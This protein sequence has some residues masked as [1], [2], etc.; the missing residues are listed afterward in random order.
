MNDAGTAFTSKQMD[1]SGELLIGG[2]SGPEPSTL[3]EGEAIDITNGDGSITIAAETA[4]DTN[5][6]VAKFNTDNFL[7]TSG[8]VTIKDGGITTP[9]IADD[10]VTYGKIQNVAK[11]TMLGR[12]ADSAGNIQELT[13]ANVRTFVNVDD[14]ANNFS[15]K[16]QANSSGAADLTNGQT[17]TLKGSGAT[18]VARS[19]NTFTISSTNTNTWNANS[20]TVA[21]YVKKGSDGGANKVW[22]TDASGNPGWRDDAN[23]TYTRASFID[24]DVNK[25]SNVQFKGITADGDISMAT[26]LVHKGDTDTYISFLDNSIAFVTAGVQK[27]KI[28]STSVGGVKF[29]GPGTIQYTDQSFY[30][31]L[32]GDEAVTF[33]GLPANA[34][35]INVVILTTGFEHNGIKSLTN[36]GCTIDRYNKEGDQTVTLRIWHTQI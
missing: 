36:T 5:L 1:G 21:G 4:T 34:Q 9:E 13:A 30:S 22:K 35:V 8:D 14:G 12:T 28:T 32:D 29:T 33:T 25:A 26:K 3:T 31:N 2:T 10:N 24:Q 7:V 17:L 27:L 11:K 15:F 19:S 23:T 18:S 20:K 6:G 16:V